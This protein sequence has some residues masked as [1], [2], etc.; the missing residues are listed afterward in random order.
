MCFLSLSANALV[1]PKPSPY[2][3]RVQTVDYNPD[4]VVEINTKSGVS[5][6]ILFSEGESIINEK[7]VTGFLDGWQL[8]P[9]GNSLFIKA[10][11]IQSKDSEG[12]DIFVE[13]VPGTWNTNVLVSTNRRVYVFDLKLYH[14]SPKVAFLIKFSYPEDEMRR[15]LAE[16]ARKQREVNMDKT[17]VVAN[18]SYT[19]KARRRSKNI[20]PSN[21]FDDGEFTYFTFPGNK[22]IPAI[23]HVNENKE[24][25]IVNSHIDPKMPGTVVVHRIGRQ[26]YLRYGD[27]VVA[28]YNEAFD[29]VGKLNTAG[30]TVTGV[31]R[32]VKGHKQ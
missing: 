10:I 16:E 31:K 7:A 20:T 11:G 2:D 3:K 21:V 14:N 15:A 9:Q 23:F 26:F 1:V 28:V 24:E 29:E 25:S 22:D 32:E 4:D 30:T 17:P 8:I 18:A 19:M 6:Q 13:P 27:A 5:T 12:K